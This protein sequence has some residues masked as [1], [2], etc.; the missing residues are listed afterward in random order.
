MPLLWQTWGHVQGELVGGFGAFL[1]FLFTAG[2][3]FLRR[4]FLFTVQPCFH[5]FLIALLIQI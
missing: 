3:L 2:F 4:A 5:F 1:F